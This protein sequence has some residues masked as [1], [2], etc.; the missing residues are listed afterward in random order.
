MIAPRVV[1]VRTVMRRKMLSSAGE[2]REEMIRKAAYLLAERRGFR[3]GR[4]L[5]DWLAA[6]HQVDHWLEC[7]GAAVRPAMRI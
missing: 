1:P 4:E 6:E 3:P 7:G 2:T 5:E